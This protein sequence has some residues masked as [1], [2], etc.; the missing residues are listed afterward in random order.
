MFGSIMPRSRLGFGFPYKEL[1][2]DEEASDEKSFDSQGPPKK[3]R[4]MDS[5]LGYWAITGLLA[6][7]LVWLVVEKHQNS[8]KERFWGTYEKGFVTE[9]GMSDEYKALF[10][11]G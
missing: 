2:T 11:R 9:F 5:R 7:T 10:S 1:Q 4:L 8:K 3:K 6:A